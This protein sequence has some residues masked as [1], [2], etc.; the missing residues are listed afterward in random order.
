M[1]NLWVQTSDGKLIH[2]A[3]AGNDI[4]TP[5]SPT[6]IPTSV[7]SAALADRCLAGNVSITIAGYGPVTF[8]FDPP[9]RSGLCNQCGSCCVHPVAN[10]T[11]APGTCDFILDTKYNV[12]KC[13]HLDIKPGQGKLHNAN[14]TSC[15][16]HA[17]LVD[18]LK[19]CLYF[20]VR[21]SELSPWMNNCGFTFSV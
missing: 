2:L 21:S 18:N 1:G 15:T 10:C 6:K 8:V 4:N 12:H 3:V 5:A 7:V 9:G 16:I 11:S 13:P 14:G 20:P 19:G 17:S